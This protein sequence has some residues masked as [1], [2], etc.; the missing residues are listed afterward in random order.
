LGS[1]V[2][3]GSLLLVVAVVVVAAVVVVVVEVC[4]GTC[5]MHVQAVRSVAC[6]LLEKFK[7]I[8]RKPPARDSCI[9]A[10]VRQT[11]YLCLLNALEP[12]LVTYRHTTM[13]DI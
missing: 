9:A 1:A 4:E 12:Q 11:I 8:T 3:S 13:Y 7:A 2:L 5:F 6:K 10:S